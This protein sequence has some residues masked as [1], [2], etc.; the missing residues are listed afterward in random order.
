MTTSGPPIRRPARARWRPVAPGT[1]LRDGIERIV[2]AKMGALLILGDGPDV[3]AICSGGF[4]LD[5]AFSPQRL[6]ELAKM[7]GAIILGS[8]GSASPAPT[9]TSCPTRRCPTSETGTRHR[10]AERVARSIPVSGRQR[11]RRDGRHQRLRRRHEAPT[12]RHR[13]P[14]RPGQ[15]G[16]ADAR[17]LQGARS[18]TRW[19]ISLRSS[20]KTSS[21]SATSPPWCN[22]ARWCDESPPRSRR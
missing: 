21:R 5:A 19:R 18:T 9:C 7:D 16:T 20:S 4:L 8:D 10:T 13:P 14:A 22:A 12:A 11:Q 2:R 6:S 1:P 15:P 17:A 3:L